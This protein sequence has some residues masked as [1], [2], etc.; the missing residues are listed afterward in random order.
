[1]NNASTHGLDLALAASFKPN[2]ITKAIDL[3]RRQCKQTL[4][5][6][7]QAEAV[8]VSIEPRSA[9]WQQSAP[10]ACTQAPAPALHDHAYYQQPQYEYL[11]VNT[12]QH[13]HQHHPP[14]FASAW[15]PVSQACNLGVPT[16]W[17]TDENTPVL[18][19]TTA[20]RLAGCKLAVLFR[21]VELR[22]SCMPVY[23]EAVGV[24]PKSLY[25][26]P[27]TPQIQCS[28][29]LPSTWEAVRFR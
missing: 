7:L 13:Q 26:M 23:K 25:T 28:T 8:I 27:T 16:E 14:P 1:M 5:P 22:H 4:L 19:V 3:I 24:H 11:D 10:K 18:V 21:L 20:A 17:A 29:P 2:H 6:G 12:S 15:P 9:L